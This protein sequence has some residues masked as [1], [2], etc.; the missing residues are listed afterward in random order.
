MN[1]RYYGI[2]NCG[3]AYQ[4]ENDNFTGLMLFKK[5]NDQVCVKAIVKDQENFHDDKTIMGYVV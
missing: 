3:V 4:G 2:Q 1:L 5:I